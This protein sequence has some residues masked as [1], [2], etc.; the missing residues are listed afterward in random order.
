MGIGD[1]FYKNKFL[2]GFLRYLVG[3]VF[4]VS[5]VTKLADF[6]GTLDFFVDIL[7]IQYAVTKFLLAFLI[8]IELVLGT[9]ILTQFFYQQIVYNITIVY[10]FI[11]NWNFP[12]SK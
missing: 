6:R 11:V 4:I 7:R 2:R 10:W 5:S 9:M 12:Y 3:L 8:L 1:V